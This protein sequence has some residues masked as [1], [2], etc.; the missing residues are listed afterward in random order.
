MA[1]EVHQPHDNLFRKV[2]SETSEA[3]G[4]LRAHL[5]QW[6][7]GT[8]DWSTLRVQDRSYVDD[9]LAAS[10]SDLLFEVQWRADAGQAAGAAEPLLL[11]VLLEH[12]SRPDRWMRF[13]L[14]EYCCRIWADVLHADDTRAEL[15]S[16]VPVVFYQGER[17]WRH[18]RE[19]AEQFAE[20]ARGWPWTPR[21]E[22]L[23]VDQSQAPVG[24]VRGEALGRVAQ[25]ALMAAARRRVSRGR[26]ALRL[27][28]QY[29]GSWRGADG[30]R[31]LE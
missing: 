13:R 9:E 18:A 16:I 2:F 24:E 5:P 26:A 27:A 25:L 7:S 4:L 1:R 6:L 29:M 19:F 10:E 21:F 22:H 17:R 31:C 11:Y 8:L 15:P 23:L 3:A 20:A 28:A 12:Q 14:L 30:A